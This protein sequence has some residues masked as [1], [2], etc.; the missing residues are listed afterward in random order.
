MLG[1]RWD[2]DRVQKD[3]KTDDDGEREKVSHVSVLR[4]PGSGDTSHTHGGAVRSSLPRV[5][6]LTPGGDCPAGDIIGRLTNS[7]RSSQGNASLRKVYKQRSS[8]KRKL[9][10]SRKKLSPGSG[11]N[12]R[13][14]A[15]VTKKTTPRSQSNRNVKDRS[16]KMVIISPPEAKRDSNPS[17][18]IVENVS[19]SLETNRPDRQQCERGDISTNGSLSSDKRTDKAHC[20]IPEPVDGAVSRVVIQADV[21]HAIHS[22][23]STLKTNTPTE[24]SEI[25]GQEERTMQNG[26]EALHT[27]AL[28]QRENGHVESVSQNISADLGTDVNVQNSDTFDDSFMLDSQTV[29]LLA[30]NDPKTVKTI[31]NN[32]PVL[33]NRS[34]NDNVSERKRQESTPDMYS[35]DI[36]NFNLSH[37]E[38]DDLF[39]GIHSGGKERIP[40]KPMLFASENLNSCNIV[41]N[42]IIQSKGKNVS[43]DIFHPSVNEKVNGPNEIFKEN[44]IEKNKKKDSDTE[45]MMK[46]IETKSIQSPEMYS[47]ELFSQVRNCDNIQGHNTKMTDHLQGQNKVIINAAYL[48]QDFHLHLTSSSSPKIFSEGMDDEM[49]SSIDSETCRF[50]GNFRT[51]D[52]IMESASPE[53]V[54]GPAV[55]RQRIEVTK[56][57]ELHG[58][59]I[60]HHFDSSV[61]E[62][63]E[64]QSSYMDEPGLVASNF[65]RA[66][67]HHVEEDGLFS[68]SVEEES[69]NDDELNVCISFESCNNEDSPKPPDGADVQKCCV[70]PQSK[71]EGQKLPAVTP[72]SSGAYD[73]IHEDLAIAMNMSDTF[74]TT[75]QPTGAANENCKYGDNKVTN[76][77]QI[78]NLNMSRSTNYKSSKDST[79]ANHMADSLTFSMIENALEEE[80]CPENLT[81]NK[82]ILGSDQVTENATKCIKNHP[83][84]D[85]TADTWNMNKDVV[86][87]LKTNKLSPGTDAVLEAMTGGRKNTPAKKAPPKMLAQTKKLTNANKSVSQRASQKRRSMGKPDQKHPTPPKLSRRSHDCSSSLLSDNSDYVPPTPPGDNFANNSKISI[88]TPFSRKEQKIDTPTHELKSSERRDSLEEISFDENISLDVDVEISPRSDDLNNP[89][90]CS[91]SPSI[92]CTNTSFTII[93]VAADKRLFDHFIEEWSSQTSYAICV[94]CEKMPA[95]PVDGGGIG[96]NFQKG[97]VV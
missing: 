96:G 44:D 70:I 69:R 49:G 87:L 10:N 63:N 43:N 14:K 67:G 85:S 54:S 24:S 64:L 75:P 39:V 66:D 88:T 62:Q 82:P 93:D 9:V 84:S 12:K 28:L 60:N 38:N 65:D 34:P 71:E 45:I 25:K 90:I 2:P 86:S 33:P 73:N 72:A 19:P 97:M 32:T 8:E 61:E 18:N 83:C 94:S 35:E 31:P 89:I 77:S 37:T 16:D 7:S 50:M 29:E 76:M 79:L 21:H 5:D 74:S 80:N 36:E 78:K 48:S 47:E 42:A 22:Q 51:Q 6:Q 3:K 58:D 13:I 30:Q 1:V 92:P 41:K 27:D 26:S 40:L 23:I 59:I 52:H 55:S 11:T 81:R 53:L 91:P 4:S 57:P 95:T 56:S 68:D 20:V 46:D 15:N 17:S